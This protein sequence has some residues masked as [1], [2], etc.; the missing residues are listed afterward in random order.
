MS[1]ISDDDVNAARELLETVFAP[2]PNMPA[3]S[4]E[5]AVARLFASKQA[6]N[7][8]YVA[9]NWLV[10]NKPEGRYARDNG[11]AMLLLHQVVDQM[12]AATP[13]AETAKLRFVNSCSSHRGLT[14]ILHIAETLPELHAELDEFDADLD[15][16]NCKNGVLHLA[17][18]GIKDGVVFDKDP[19]G[20]F[21]PHSRIYKMTRMA[22]VTYR[23]DATGP[24]WEQHMSYIFMNDV[25]KYLFMQRWMGR[26]LSG[27]N[28]SD[29]DR[30]LMAIGTG[31]NGKTK[32]AEAHK[33]V[34]GDYA[35]PTDFATW[36]IPRSGAG[37]SN[38][39]PDLIKLPGVRLVITGESGKGHSL[40]ENLLKQYTGGEMVTPRGMR[41]NE[42]TIYRPQFA[43]FMSTNHEPRMHDSSRGFW[44]RFKKVVFPLEIPEAEWDTDFEAKVEKELSGI[45]N[46]LIKGNYYWRHTGLNPPESVRLSTDESREGSDP[47]Q[48][49]IDEQLEINV[50]NATLKRKT[51]YS[52]YGAWAEGC[53][54][55]KVSRMAFTDA[56][57][58]HGIKVQQSTGHDHVHVLYGVC[59]RS[60]RIEE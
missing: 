44:R 26:S 40:D 50:P 57:R 14:A 58:D 49:F 46:W 13:A 8:Y 17:A 34:M 33:S 29:N 47:F 19:I 6:D 32:T 3:D 38:P 5:L 45:L 21:L 15:L 55:Q 18:V 25:E 4:S 39:R 27:M 24:M 59:E 53:G 2:N 22:G 28:P 43:L 23:R 41:A 48:Q 42:E 35:E 60:F 30:I 37:G 54:L 10:Y 9:G 11:A 20:V 31:A 16:L 7:L 51:A 12:R 56:M 52:L 36:C 1:D